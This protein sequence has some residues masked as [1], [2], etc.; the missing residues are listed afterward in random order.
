MDDVQERAKAE[1]PHDP[2][3]Q[4]HL[5]RMAETIRNAGAATNSLG[6]SVHAEW[7]SAATLA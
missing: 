7:G 4:T 6:S 1:V 3:L 5:R 2:V